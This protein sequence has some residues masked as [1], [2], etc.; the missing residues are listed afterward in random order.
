MSAPW[1]ESSF[2][3]VLQHEYAGSM[4][5]DSADS[6]LHQPQPPQQPCQL[7]V[8]VPFCEVLCPFC[9]FHRVQFREEKARGYFNALRQE[10]RSYHERGFQFSDVYVGGGTP[11]VVPAELVET[12]ELIR[13]LWP[14]RTISVE[15]NP[16]HLTEAVFAALQ[17]VGVGR[18]SVGVQSFDDGLLRQMQRYDKYGSGAAIRERLAE[19]NGKFRTL[20]VD[21]I[22][23]LPNQSLEML[24]RDL[25]TL[26]ELRVDQ[27][28]FYPLM[29]AATARHRMEKSLG[30]ADPGRRYDFYARILDAMQG[31]HSASAAGTAPYVPA[32]TWCFS[33]NDGAPGA[34]R[35]I[36]EYII[37]Q[38]DYVGVG[39]GS[40]SYVGGWMYST[41]FSLNQYRDRIA[42]GLPA[43]TQS[44]RLTLKERMRYDY[45]VRLFGLSLPYDYIRREYGRSFWI[46]MAPE[47][48]SMRLLGATR[49]DAD[50]IRLTPL[51]MYCWVLM[52][53]E[54][55][56]AVNAFR[57][58]MRLHIRDELEGA[59]ASEVAV[60]LSAVRHAHSATRGK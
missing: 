58:E 41:T 35:M 19:A 12:L 16:N 51:G 5:F 14:V 44:K 18:L 48:L 50:G 23:N 54:F 43:I 2:V 49:H 56:N 53:A 40:F 31:G 17:S 45:L 46:H 21:M 30:T 22:F 27:I 38:D 47:V 15:T 60:P 20:N 34:P 33:R 32:S 13:S 42:R 24:E 6:K 8:H 28:S 25:Q 7:Y 26:L 9:S 39:S 11:T 3:R 57:D 10:I 59:A 4:H 55:F 37:D 36:D 1:F 52:M 29:T